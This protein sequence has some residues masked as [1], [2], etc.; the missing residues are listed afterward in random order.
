M[1]VW[2]VCVTLNLM[3]AG[4]NRRRSRVFANSR[5]ISTFALYKAAFCRVLASVCE[6]LCLF[7]ISSYIN[8]MKV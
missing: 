1:A 5:F 7:M 3:V 8:T 6:V 2:I 4:W